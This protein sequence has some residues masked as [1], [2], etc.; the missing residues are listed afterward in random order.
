MP[1]KT[2]HA[3]PPK[4]SLNLA[5]KNLDR[6]IKFFTD[7]GYYINPHFTGPTAACVVLSDENDC[8]LLTEEFFKGF[9]DRPLSDPKISTASLVALSCA[10]RAEVDVMVNKAV[11]LGGREIRPAQAMDVMYL[12]SFEDLDGHIWEY[13]W[14]D[15]NFR[16]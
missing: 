2:P 8:M 1:E 7:M 10:T 11:K 3:Q 14:M 16:G 13:Y 5:V 6:S 12:R 4:L 15:P 9:I